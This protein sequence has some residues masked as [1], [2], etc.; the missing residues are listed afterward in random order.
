[1]NTPREAT[2]LRVS[3]IGAGP[4]GLAV[5]KAISDAGHSL[6]SIS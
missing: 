3:V 2:R 5:A 4:V 1:M 6:M